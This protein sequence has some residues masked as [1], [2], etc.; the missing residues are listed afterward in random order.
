MLHLSS[1]ILLFEHFS[2]IRSC[3]F[4]NRHII[5][6]NNIPT[7]SCLLLQIKSFLHLLVQRVIY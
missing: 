6:C 7:Y 5:M 1:I 2:F 3:S 4:T